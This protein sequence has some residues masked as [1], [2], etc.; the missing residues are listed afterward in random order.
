MKL[1]ISPKDNGNKL[2]LQNVETFMPEGNTLGVVFNN[3][4]QTELPVP[5]S[6]V[7]GYGALEP[8]TNETCQ[9]TRPVSTLSDFEYDDD[10]GWGPDQND[11]HLEIRTSRAAAV[12]IVFLD[13][14]A[15]Y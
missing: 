12:V 15:N 14:S 9:M 3:G 7:L 6:L 5:T 4:A 8:S 11:T 13:R 1:I 2:V 10:L